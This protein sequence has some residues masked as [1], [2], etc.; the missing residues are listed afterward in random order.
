MVIQDS[1]HRRSSQL[2]VSPNLISTMKK[3][4]KIGHQIFK[5]CPALLSI[6]AFFAMSGCDSGAGIDP[7]SNDS[8]ATEAIELIRYVY[9]T[10]DSG[11][12]HDVKVTLDNNLVHEGR[13][14]ASEDEYYAELDRLMEK[15]ELIVNASLYRKFIHALNPAEIYLIDMEGDVVIGKYV[16]TTTEVGAHKYVIDDPSSKPEL[17]EYWGKDGQEMER[18]VLD[19]I[20]LM[21]RPEDMSS[22]S[23]KNPFIQAQADEFVLAAK[24]AS[25]S[26]RNKSFGDLP[27]GRY[28]DTKESGIHTVC[29]PSERASEANLSQRCYSIK[30]IYWNQSTH[31]KRRRALGGTEVMVLFQG[32]WY[33]LERQGPSGLGSRIMLEVSASG[34]HSTRMATCTGRLRVGNLDYSKNPPYSQFLTTDCESIMV[35][36]NRRSRRGTTSAHRVGFIDHFIPRVV[37]GRTYLIYSPSS[38]WVDAQIVN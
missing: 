11:E 21:G 30:F 3:F 15:D 23:F 4:S 9:G 14:F 37:N 33:D 27:T 31:T 34:G 1:L 38:S 8:K 28:L 16:H 5:S 10:F 32:A 6:V 29:L 2:T 17:E 19:F 36:A 26:Q 7:V 25:S 18:E 12:E 13:L 22:I 20:K 35:V 24:S